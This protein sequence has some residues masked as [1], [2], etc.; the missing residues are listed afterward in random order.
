[1]TRLMDLALASVA[2]IVLSPVMVAI[3]FAVK[4]SS[5]GPVLYRQSR[6]G[7]DGRLFDILKFRTM[8]HEDTV[9]PLV[10]ADGDPRVT[11]VGRCLRSTKLD[12]LPQLVNVLRGDMAIVGPRPEVPAYVALWGAEKRNVILSVRPG[13]TD[14]VTVRFRREAEILAMN[15]DPERLYREQILPAKAAAYV[16]YVETKTLR[17]DLAILWNTAKATMLR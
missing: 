1:M 3:A 8:K 10:T 12:E 9:G 14:P 13:I 6:A 11:R 4:L 15:D 7:R 16:T 5:H 17:G 2:L